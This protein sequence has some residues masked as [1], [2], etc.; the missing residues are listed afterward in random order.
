MTEFTRVKFYVP[1]QAGNK[2][3]SPEHTMLESLKENAADTF[4]G[5]TEYEA[6]G[7][8]IPNG[9]DQVEEENVVV[10]EILSKEAKSTTDGWVHANANWL[11]SHTDEDVI[12][13]TVGDEMYEL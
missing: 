9:E 11:K 2:T 8:W 10:L 3:W 5:Y 1:E 6:T 13:A 7:G 4:G 12:L